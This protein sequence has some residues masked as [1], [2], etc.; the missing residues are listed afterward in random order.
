MAT[1]KQPLHQTD[2]ETVPVIDFAPF[3]SGKSQEQEA[4][5]DEIARACREVGFF[6]L[7]NHGVDQDLIE[8]TFAEARQFFALDETTKEAVGWQEEASN[9]GYVK[10]GRESLNPRRPGDLKE[11]FN[12]GGEK[13]QQDAN[14]AAMELNQWPEHN[15]TFR[16][17]MEAFF[18]AC[19]EGANNVLHAFAIALATPPEFFIKHH[20]GRDHTMR[21][22]HYPPVDAQS[23]KPGQK[24][25]GGH[26]DYGS[27]TLLFQD[28]VGGLEVKNVDGVWCQAPPIPDTI[29]INTG[30][31]MQRWTN[32]SFRSTPHR[33]GLPPQEAAHRMRDSIAFFCHPNMDSRIECLP[34]CISDGRPARYPAISS[35]DHLMER[36]KVT[37]N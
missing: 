2:D 3:L 35:Y 34:S 1:S 21:L 9:R 20:A 18:D 24:R 25:A 13:E 10:V 7:R 26:T 36:L 30:D 22:L 6:Y 27:I 12:I 31:L 19:A 4:V 29:L 17:T 37:Y 16:P 15:M 5:A 8:R 32:D 14:Q 23:L 33:V 11:A 28:D